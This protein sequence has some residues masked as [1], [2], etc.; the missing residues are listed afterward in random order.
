MLFWLKPLHYTSLNTFPS[1]SSKQCLNFADCRHNI[2]STCI[3]ILYVLHG[4]SFLG[5]IS[6][7]TQEKSWWGM[8]KIKNC[9][10]PSTSPSN[11]FQFDNFSSYMI[12]VC[13]QGA[14]YACRKHETW[15]FSEWWLNKYSL[16]LVSVQECRVHS[17][18]GTIQ[19][20]Y[21]FQ[22]HGGREYHVEQ[23]QHES[24]PYLKDNQ[25]QLKMTKNK[26]NM[27]VPHSEQSETYMRLSLLCDVTCSWVIDVFIAVL[28]YCVYRPLDL[29]FYGC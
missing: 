25:E 21:G 2:R 9:V 13:I 5:H 17:D 3:S 15:A 4:I 6:Q 23:L 11:G 26:F 10:I 19:L 18:S 14:K 1:S 8:L 27:K 28:I 16:Q 20:D 29:G 24:P 7:G 12:T 22:S